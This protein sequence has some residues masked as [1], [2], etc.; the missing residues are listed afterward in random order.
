M[1]GLILFLVLSVPSISYGQCPTCVPRTRIVFNVPVYK[2]NVE[3]VKPAK[4]RP[5]RFNFFRRLFRR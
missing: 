2:N 5:Q 3:P 1:K 4:P